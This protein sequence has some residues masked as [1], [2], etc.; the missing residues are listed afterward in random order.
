MSEALE[1]YSKV[2]YNGDLDHLKIVKE[3]KVRAD[4][5]AQGREYIGN[6]FNRVFPNDLSTTLYLEQRFEIPMNAAGDAVV[7]RGVIDRIAKG[8][9][10]TIR[11][12][13]YKTGKVDHPLD[14]LQ[15]PSYAL[16][17]F[18][19]NI[20]QE[21]E[22][23]YEDLREHRTVVVRFNR[24]EVKKVRESL[25]RE[26]SAIRATLPEGFVT[27]PSILC[28]WCGYNQICDNPHESVN[29][30]KTVATTVR[31]TSSLGTNGDFQGACPLCGGELAEKKGKFGPFLGC[32]NYPECRYTRDLGRTGGDPIKDPDVDGKDICP[33]CGGLLKQRKGKYG[34][35]MGCSNYP[36]CRFSRQITT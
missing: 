36:E 28:L 14:T 1:Q 11:V 32:R 10:G 13:D 31:A 3:D 22:L 18:M 5:Y 19:H 23:C 21:I 29:P 34:A 8:M 27:N 26:M 17:I 12:T 35:F 25:E 20:D 33:E 9:D 30:K 6:F 2:W 24:K 15:L 7:Y 16:Y 4:Y